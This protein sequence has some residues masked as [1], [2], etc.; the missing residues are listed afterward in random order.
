M[1][2]IVCLIKRQGGTKV[3]IDGV[4]YH[5][6]PEKDDGP[7][8][9]EVTNPAHVARFIGIPEAYAKLGEEA[10]AA[11][12]VARAEEAKQPVAP[13]EKVEDWS[14][15]KAMAYGAQ[16]LKINPKDKTQILALGQKHGVTLDESKSC[17]AMIRTL[18][19]A[20]G[21]QDDED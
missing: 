16:V 13:V 10:K 2:K 17:S 6:K 8:V 11:E 4:N 18:V 20:I 12:V 5:F 15:K 7:H 21:V 14:N 19:A 9:A 1:T 3:D